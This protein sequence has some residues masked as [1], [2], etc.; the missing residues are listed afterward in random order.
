MEAAKFLAAV[1]ICLSHAGVTG[2]VKTIAGGLAFPAVAMFFAISGYFSYGVN[3]KKLWKRLLHI[4]RLYL[5]AYAIHLLCNCV[6]IELG[7]GSTVAY[8]RGAL[9]EFDE[10]VLWITIQQDPILGHMWTMASTALSYLTL[11]VYVRFFEE[12]KTDY[13][14]L[15]LV[16]LALFSCYLAMGVILPAAGTELPLRAFRNHWFY[17]LPCFT[18]GIF[19][20][21]YQDRIWKQYGLKPLAL[22]AGTLASLTL[23]ILDFRLMIPVGVVFLMLLV[24]A[25]PGLPCGK[26]A[27][28]AGSLSTGI[29]VLHMTMIQIYDICLAENFTPAAK[30]WLVLAMSL[31]GAVV[32]DLVVK[33]GKK[34]K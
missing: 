32:W 13:R 6:L 3:S 23:V 22:A 10:V 31:C 12:G 16:S 4:L 1:L 8:L 17:G 7:G 14:P 28:K 11:W 5:A 15:Y 34:Q 25:S 20:H 2:L 21:Q 9:P 19:L 27:E 30:P 33:M 26:L 24:I 18:L 29:Y